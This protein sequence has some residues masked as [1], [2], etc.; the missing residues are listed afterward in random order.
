M[1][2]TIVGNKNMNTS[3]ARLSLSTLLPRFV[4]SAL[5]FV[6]SCLT[7]FITSAQAQIHVIPQPLHLTAQ[8]GG[9]ILSNKTVIGVDQ[10]SETVGKYLQAYLNRYYKLNLKVKVYKHIPAN[11]AIKL[12]TGN[13]NSIEGAYTLSV[14]PGGIKITGN[15]AGVFYGVQSLIQLLPAKVAKP[16]RVAA[17]KIA[18][19]PRFQWRGLSLDVS[20]HFF[21][22]DEVKKYID[23]MAHYKLNVFHWHL[24]DDEGWRIQIDKYPRL[25]EVGSK[26][27]YYAKQG[28]FRKLDNLIDD[29]RDGFY[30]KAEIR[31]VIKYAQ[32]RFVTI[33][34]EIEMPGHS[35]AAIFAYPELGCQDS[36]GAKHRVRM[37]DPSEDTFKFMEDVL[38]EVIGLFPNQY[39]HIGGDEA[40]MADWL[41]S[42]VA[43]ALMKKEGL[44]NEK[45]VQSY[46]VKRIERF[47][48]S[49]NKK[50][51]GWD[52][53]LQGGLA[54]SATVMSWQGEAGGITAA[55]MHHHVVMTPLPYMY[56]DAPQANEDLEPIGWN[57]PV[58]WQMVYNYEPRSSQLTP[59]EAEY[60][61]GAQGN[62]WT[63]KVPNLRHLEYMVYPR[64]LAVAELTWS[65]KENKN[66]SRFEYKIKQ[67]YGL[68]KLWNLNARLPDIVG[69]DNITTNADL[70][71]TTLKYPL[72]GA[73]VRYSLDNNMPDSTAKAIAFPVNINVP[74]KDSLVLKTYTT[75]TLNKQRILQTATIKRVVIAAGAINT[76]GLKAGLDY[77]L[78]KTK[79][80]NYAKLDTIPPVT[81]AVV[82]MANPEVLPVTDGNLTWVKFNGYIKIDQEGDYELTSGFEVSPALFIGSQLLI[83]PDKN[84]YAEPQKALLHLKKGVYEFSGYYIANN[85]NSKQT[86]LQLKTAA[87]KLLDPRAYLFHL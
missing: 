15:G 44:K 8:K 36:T 51:V 24:T 63:E 37:L 6:I 75:W 1:G 59:A 60:I 65:L 40:E 34:P 7:L 82:N 29:G 11:N 53:I 9:F 76:A 22:V 35:E 32:D 84:T 85:I 2:I 47:L 64:A 70:F 20:R 13:N 81:I 33:L 23:V 57:P 66:I 21:T 79:E 38:T 42:P 17:C 74:L 55:K 87:G 52:E 16:L 12:I 48:V 80:T 45:E 10:Q 26:I 56:F 4:V 72:L 77:K 86:L 39:I 28:K 62:I 43:V 18:D 27:S 78:I 61:L 69:V 30:T 31:D 5:V 3:P 58:T 46:F 49:K 71:K 83:M 67:Q 50:L 73:H 68:F 14:V 25:T 54:E 41:K 19:E